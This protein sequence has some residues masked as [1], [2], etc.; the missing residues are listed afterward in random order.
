MQKK[1]QKKKENISFICT[2][3][4]LPLVAKKYVSTFSFKSVALLLSSGSFVVLDLH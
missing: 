2:S 4:S 3:F 1:K